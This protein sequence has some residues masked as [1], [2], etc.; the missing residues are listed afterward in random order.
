ML[1]LY[2]RAVDFFI[3]LRDALRQWRALPGEVKRLKREIAR[4]RGHR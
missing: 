1:H 3:D 2:Y 4:L